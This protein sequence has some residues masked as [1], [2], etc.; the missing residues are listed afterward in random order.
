MPFRK[1]PTPHSRNP[2]GRAPSDPLTAC[3]DAESTYICTA[4]NP[5]CYIIQ[6]VNQSGLPISP[7]LY[8][9]STCGAFSNEIEG[10]GLDSNVNLGA[11]GWDHCQSTPHPDY[12]CH[13]SLDGKIERS[14]RTQN[15]RNASSFAISIKLSASGFVRFGHRRLGGATCRIFVR[16]TSS[17][18]H[19][20]LR[21]PFCQFGVKLC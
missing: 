13:H 3:L 14:F 10:S 6:K 4:F 19:V 9:P 5:R 8:G 17:L 7:P 15:I 20:P 1:G 12:P 21:R 18:W 16:F 2:P 11:H